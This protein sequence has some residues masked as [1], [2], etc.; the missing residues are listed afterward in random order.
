MPVI[1]STLKFYLMA[2]TASGKFGTVEV[3][4]KIFKIIPPPNLFPSYPELQER[5]NIE[6]IYDE[7][8]NLTTTDLRNFT[9]G[10]LE[11]PENDESVVL[12]IENRLAYV[13]TTLNED[14]S[15]EVQVDPSLVEDTD[16]GC[17]EIKVKLNDSAHQFDEFE[18]V[19]QKICINIT[20]E[21]PEPELQEPSTLTPPPP[22]PDPVETT[23]SWDWE[24]LDKESTEE[25]EEV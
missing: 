15:F 21:E 8:G 10:P 7:H 11:D 22:P 24:A 23:F 9:S 12:E 17:Q 14:G 4:S 18:E 2:I 6:V 3:S 25:K 5:V 19:T 1:Q 13:T 16:A 20:R